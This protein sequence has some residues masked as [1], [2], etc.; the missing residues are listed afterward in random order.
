M[1]WLNISAVGMTGGYFFV[2]AIVLQGVLFLYNSMAD[3]QLTLRVKQFFFACSWAH[4]SEICHPFHRTILKNLCFLL[5]LYG[6]LSTACQVFIF[7]VCL[8]KRPAS[9][10]HAHTL[11]QSVSNL[12]YSYMS[13]RCHMSCKRKIR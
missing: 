13:F 1:N 5:S 8:E 6:R 11:V 3:F 12:S 10:P 2:L 7:V 9:F 4:V